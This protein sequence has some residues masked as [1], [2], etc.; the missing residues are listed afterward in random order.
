MQMDRQSYAEHYQQ[1]SD[2][3]LEHLAM[4]ESSELVPEALAALRDELQRRG[5]GAIAEQAEAQ[6]H[7]IETLV[8][9][10]RQAPCPHC[11]ST[12]RKLN[13]FRIGSAISMLLVT[14]YDA[15]VVVACPPCLASAARGASTTSMLLGWWGFP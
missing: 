1:L 8:E 9:W 7:E 15:K 10:V 3:R 13:V 12:A 11:R 6:Q 14:F 5:L 4:A 2:E